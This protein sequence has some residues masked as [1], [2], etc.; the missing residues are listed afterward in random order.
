MVIVPYQSV[1]AWI[2]SDTRSF[3]IACKFLPENFPIASNIKII[4]CVLVGVFSRQNILS[5]RKCRYAQVLKI[6]SKIIGYLSIALYTNDQVDTQLY[7]H[8]I[9]HMP[10][11]KLPFPRKSVNESF[12]EH[13]NM[14]NGE[15]FLPDPRHNINVLQILA[16]KNLMPQTIILQDHP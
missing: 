10:G 16:Y 13:K 2:E 15:V 12:L 7:V 6:I 9:P 3:Q 1:R 8:A 5:L 11:K 14:L 4:N